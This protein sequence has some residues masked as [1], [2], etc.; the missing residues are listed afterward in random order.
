MNENAHFLNASVWRRPWHVSGLSGARAVP[1]T[2]S[3]LQDTKEIDSWTY[4]CLQYVTQMWALLDTNGKV[5]HL[6]SLH[7]GLG[8]TRHRARWL[9]PSRQARTGDV[10]GGV[11]LSSAVGWAGP[12]PCPSPSRG[13]RNVVS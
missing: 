13:H 5:S 4:V 2:A 8:V 7:L 1:R 9:L 12:L 10:A 11:L 6:Q 3:Q